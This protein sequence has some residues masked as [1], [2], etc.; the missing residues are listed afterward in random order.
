MSIRLLAV[1]D[2]GVELV[3]LLLDEDESIWVGF[4]PQ[5]RSNTRMHGL[6]SDAVLQAKPLIGSSESR[7]NV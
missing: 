3:M 2:D 5:R 6:N 7:G 4:V 1:I